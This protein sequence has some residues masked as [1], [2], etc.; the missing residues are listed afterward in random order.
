MLD[1]DGIRHQSA[2]LENEPSVDSPANDETPPF[3]Q[4]HYSVLE[5]S[6]LWS[7][8]PPFVRRLFEREPDVL[9]LGSARPP[10]YKR[11]YV[12]LRIPEF[13]LERVHRRLA[14]R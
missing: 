14:R 8:S 1:L 5:I 7:L 6:R 3:A 12:T 11:R 9:I 4:Q 10:R 13:V 2:C